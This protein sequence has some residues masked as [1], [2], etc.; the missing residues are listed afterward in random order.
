MPNSPSRAERASAT[1]LRWSSSCSFCSVS[2]CMAG[3]IWSAPWSMASM[4]SSICLKACCLARASA[5]LPSDSLA[6]ASFSWRSTSASCASMSSRMALFSTSMRLCSM[7]TSTRCWITPE[8][9]AEATPFKDSKAGTS[10]SS[11]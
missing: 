7:V 2:C 10:S 5:F 6:W 1:C 4:A 8:A 3:S 11:T 9:L